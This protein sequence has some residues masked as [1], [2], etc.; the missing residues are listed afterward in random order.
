MKRTQLPVCFFC[1]IQSVQRNQT[2][3]NCAD[4]VITDQSKSVWFR[5]YVRALSWTLPVCSILLNAWPTFVRIT[6]RILF[7]FI[8]ATFWLNVGRC[9]TR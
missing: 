6:V 4:T 3:L 1:I 2:K 9:Q 7:S 8:L 5:R